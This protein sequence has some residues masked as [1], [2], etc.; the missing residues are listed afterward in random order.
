MAA[1]A[2]EPAAEVLGLDEPCLA[3]VIGAAVDEPQALHDLGDDP[4]DTGVA[5]SG[6]LAAGELAPPRPVL[7]Q[8][9]QGGHLSGAAQ[10]CKAL[11]GDVAPVGRTLL[12]G[13][14]M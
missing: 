9:E 6:E 8:V 10:V 1:G 14:P 12:L 11:Q 2:R 5:P 4:P 7:R 13:V 3:G